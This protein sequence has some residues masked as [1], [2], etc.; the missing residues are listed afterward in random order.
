[1]QEGHGF[2]ADSNIFS[3]AEEAFILSPS[4][5]QIYEQQSTSDFSSRLPH[6]A[7]NHRD[8]VL[9]D[10]MPLDEEFSFRWQKISPMAQ[11]LGGSYAT[12]PLHWAINDDRAFVLPCTVP[13]SLQQTP[14]Q[15]APGKSE[16]PDLELELEDFPERSVLSDVLQ[17]GAGRVRQRHAWLLPQMPHPRYAKHEDW[18]AGSFCNAA[19]SFDDGGVS[20]PL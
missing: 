10:K 17:E 7:G 12:R 15:Q 9:E 5:E 8:P 6:I 14:K 11:K 20:L 18:Q 3:P 1:M 2:L 16:E 19:R 4:R 13:S